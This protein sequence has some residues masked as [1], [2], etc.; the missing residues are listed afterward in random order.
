MIDSITH[1]YVQVIEAFKVIM[2]IAATIPLFYV[3]FKL[4][5]KIIKAIFDK[6]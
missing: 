1:I 5:A 4:F 3:M 2:F 6:D